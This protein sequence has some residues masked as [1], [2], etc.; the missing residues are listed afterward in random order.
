MN[1]NETVKITEEHINTF[2][3]SLADYVNDDYQYDFIQLEKTLT[4]FIMNHFSTGYGKEEGYD[5]IFIEIM[6][7]HSDNVIE[8]GHIFIDLSEVI[9]LHSIFAQIECNLIDIFYATEY[10]NF[11]DLEVSLSKLTF[12]K[13]IKTILNG[14]I[15]CDY[16]DM[17]IELNKAVR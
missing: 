7:N 8:H 16:R 4:K 14:W 5:K 10:N 12:C 15:H 13:M 2:A 1:N 3:T 17:Q 6:N 9:K 11:S